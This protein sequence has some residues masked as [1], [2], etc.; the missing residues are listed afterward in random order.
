MCFTV[1]FIDK[2]WTC[3]KKKNI[4]FGVF[5][6]LHRGEAVDKLLSMVVSWGTE[7]LGTI[8]VDNAS[9]NNVATMNLNRKLTKRNGLLC[10]MSFSM[11]GVLLIS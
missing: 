1:Q 9:S 11:S 4:I 2:N 3:K 10:Q 5:P 7:K 6:T 8:I